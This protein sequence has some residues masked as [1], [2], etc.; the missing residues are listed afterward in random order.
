MAWQGDGDK[1]DFS[2]PLLSQSYGVDQLLERHERHIRKLVRKPWF[3][4]GKIKVAL[5][6]NYSSLCLGP[7]LL[8][9]RVMQLFVSN[10]QT[11]WAK[12]F[13]FIFLN[14]VQYKLQKLLF[15]IWIV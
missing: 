13:I 3:Q 4:R 7:S 2:G 14:K 5:T 10:K 12:T 1:I 15:L 9:R 11:G 6:D 8:Q